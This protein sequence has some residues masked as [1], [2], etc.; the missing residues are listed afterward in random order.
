MDYLCFSKTF[1][2]GEL[3]KAS[4][5]STCDYEIEHWK[6]RWFSFKPKG[7]NI[8]P[9]IIWWVFHFLGV[10]HSN[11][12]SVVLIRRLDGRIVHRTCLFPKFFRFPFMDMNDVQVGDI[13]T[14]SG[15]RGKSV[16]SLALRYISE[17][18]SPKRIWYITDKCNIA[19]VNL[20]KK[21]G[22]K[23]EFKAIKVPRF[24]L[25]FLGYYSKAPN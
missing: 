15:E 1:E 25:R 7:I 19:S 21:N 5:A 10:F 3:D 18:L 2:E 23:L 9:F 17:E 4:E 16:A 20:A 14:A 13:L 22:F 11:I 6:P 8:C 12:Y 24:G